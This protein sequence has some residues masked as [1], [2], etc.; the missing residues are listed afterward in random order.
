M[1]RGPPDL[2][3]STCVNQGV[4]TA[5]IKSWRGASRS[6][7]KDPTDAILSI[8]KTLIDGSNRD[9]RSRSD[10]HDLIEMVHDGPFH[11]NRRS[12]RLDGYEFSPYKTKCSSSFLSIRV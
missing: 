9:R 12:K 5:K 4:I 2:I 7:D 1:E 8:F 10:G 3:R 11:C 6:S